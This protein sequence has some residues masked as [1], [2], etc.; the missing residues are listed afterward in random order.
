MHMPKKSLQKSP[1]DTFIFQ[2]SASLSARYHKDLDSLIKVV[3]E[4][5]KKNLKIVMTQGVFDLIHE[6]HARYLE[7]AK[8]YG[9]VLIVA[10][11]SDKL[12]KVRK[13]DSRPV[14]PE[15][16]RIEMLTHLRHVDVVVKQDIK[17]GKGELI[18]LIKPDVL[19][20]SSST[21]DFTESMVTAYGPYCKEIIT[22]PPQAISSTSARIRRLTM[23]G[24]E[25]L[26]EEVNQLTHEFIEK[27][28]NTA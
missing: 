8:S 25:K 3:E 15:D 20:T 17:Y 10:V 21:K 13:G 18:R 24:A 22:L 26:A 1:D 14:V 2:P 6:G 16:E 12:T 5:R 7:I 19:I 11:D 27:I 23:E 9:D 4:L 28:R